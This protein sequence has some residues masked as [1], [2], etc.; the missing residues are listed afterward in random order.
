PVEFSRRS[1]RGRLTLVID[2]RGDPVL[3]YAA[4]SACPTTDTAI[5]ELRSRE[6]QR[7]R[8]EDIGV[9]VGNEVIRSRDAEAGARIRAW[10]TEKHVGRVIWTD[11]RSEWPEFSLAR[12]VA[13]LR[14]LND[15]DR[16]H[17]RIYF[18]NAPAETNT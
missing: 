5:E 7:V 13:H 11:L 3:T 10:A 18:L 2:S 16:E 17:A 8:T 14:D 15:A 6:G 4:I 9:V 12:A 1:D